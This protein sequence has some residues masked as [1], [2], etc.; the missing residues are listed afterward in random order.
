MFRR[1][2]L[3]YALRQNLKDAGGW[4]LPHARDSTGKRSRTRGRR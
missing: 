1:K 3:A 2:T 4:A